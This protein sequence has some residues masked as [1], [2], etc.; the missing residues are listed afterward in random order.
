MVFKFLAPNK[1]CPKAE[2]PL[3]TAP[4]FTMDFNCSCNA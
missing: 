1:F 2:S 4:L 3:F